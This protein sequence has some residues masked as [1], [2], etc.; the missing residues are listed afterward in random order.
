MAEE[1][2]ETVVVENDKDRGSFG[3]IIGLVIFIILVALFFMSGGFGMF[4][5]GSGA[6]NSTDVQPTTTGQ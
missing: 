5:G 2:H 4:S 1:R 3:W 6:N